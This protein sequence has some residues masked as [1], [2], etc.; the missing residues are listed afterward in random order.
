M[1]Q[2]PW[3]LK[4]G[5][6]SSFSNLREAMLYYIYIYIYIYIYCRYNVRY[7]LAVCLGPILTD[8]PV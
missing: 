7:K 8:L 4:E 1:C 6:A 5:L 2:R 3:Q